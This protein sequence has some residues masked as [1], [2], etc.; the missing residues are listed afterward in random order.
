MS[1][2]KPSHFP[3][4]DYLV[5]KSDVA[6]CVLR[7]G[8]PLDEYLFFWDAE[9]KTFSTDE[10]N[11]VIDF[12]GR[13]SHTIRVG[14]HCMLKV[15]PC[16]VLHTGP[17]CIFQTDDKCKFYTGVGCVFQTGKDCTFKTK[18]LGHIHSFPPPHFAGSRH[19]IG[20]AS[21]GIIQCGCITNPVAWW[22]KNMVR[23]AEE[24]GYTAE[25]TV[26]Y[27]AYLD[28]LVLWAERVG[29]LKEKIKLLPF[30]GQK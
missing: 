27:Q 17:Y 3:A 14:S 25:Q 28:L 29:W 13:A 7:S 10:N 30:G 8:K 21:P 1:N 4:C 2:T 15:G 6:K 24:N 19:G 20:F 16:C 18:I 23:C 22:R 11:L 26:E 9:A 12:T 5:T